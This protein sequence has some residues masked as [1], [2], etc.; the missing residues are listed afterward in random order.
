MN[1]LCITV[2]TFSLFIAMGNHIIYNTLFPTSRKFKTLNMKAHK[3]NNI[4]SVILS[5]SEYYQ[6]TCILHSESMFSL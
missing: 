3:I 5:E 4:M 1:S 2:Q 6:L